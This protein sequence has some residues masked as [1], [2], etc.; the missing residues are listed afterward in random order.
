M[1]RRPPRSTLFP[2]TT[3][4]RSGPISEHALA[5]LWSAAGEQGEADRRR[6]PGDRYAAHGFPA[7]MPVLTA[8]A[9]RGDEGRGESCRDGPRVPPRCTRDARADAAPVPAAWPMTCTGAYASYPVPSPNWP[10]PL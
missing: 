10:Q 6:K 3:L 1:I 7:F 9:D 2:Y 4:F 8:Q 5:R